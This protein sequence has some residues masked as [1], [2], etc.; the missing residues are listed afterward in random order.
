MA[1]KIESISKGELSNL[2]EQ[3]NNLLLAMNG[4]HRF[5]LVYTCKPFILGAI[6]SYSK[7]LE[8]LTRSMYDKPRASPILPS[9]ENELQ[10]V[11][12][13][14]FVMLLSNRHLMIVIG[15]SCRKFI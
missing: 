10:S 3:A 15:F 2:S 13:I 11:L 6:L 4:T 1:S 7:Y 14:Y 5:D 8:G 9:I 12:R